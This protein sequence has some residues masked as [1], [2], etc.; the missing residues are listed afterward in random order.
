MICPAGPAGD[1][2]GPD[3]TNKIASFLSLFL[4]HA[5]LHHSLTAIGPSLSPADPVPLLMSDLPILFRSWNTGVL[6]GMQG[7]WNSIGPW[8]LRYLSILISL[9]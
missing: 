1:G 7:D 4:L 9:L 8:L 6:R 5:G 2:A 3:C